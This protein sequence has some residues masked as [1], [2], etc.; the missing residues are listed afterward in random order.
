MPKLVTTEDVPAKSRIC[1]WRQALKDLYGSQHDIEVGL[2]A[3]FHASLSWRH[4]GPATL[5]ESSGSACRLVRHADLGAGKLLVVAQTEGSCTLSQSGRTATLEAGSFCVLPLAERTEYEFTADFRQ[6]ALIFDVDSLAQRVP[7]WGRRTCQRIAGNIGAGGVFLSLLQAMRQHQKSLEDKCC[8][9]A[10]Q[11]LVGLL[12]VAMDELETVARPTTRMASYHKDRVRNFV[13][14]Q[15]GNPSLDISMVAA[16]LGISTRYVYH[17]F[18]DE[19]MHLMQWIWTQR[20]ERCRQ[21]LTRQAM[22]GRSISSIAFA[23]GFNDPAHFSR[24]FRKHF[25]ISP[26]EMRRM[27]SSQGM[28][29]AP[30]SALSVKKHFSFGQDA[31]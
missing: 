31:H 15:L 11:A 24:S 4:N 10:F 25:G 8:Q 17:L 28:T 12:A 22:S 6:M 13:L 7:D 29:G 9:E 27:A 3:S 20:L 14:S 18:S 30:V 26:R 19:D 23:W 5:I 16:E 21:E 1:F 2:E